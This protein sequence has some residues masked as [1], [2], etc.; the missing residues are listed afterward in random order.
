MIRILFFYVLQNF[1]S[2]I[3][4]SNFTLWCYQDLLKGIFFEVKKKFETALGV[5][6]KEKITIDPD[7]PAAVSCYAQVMKTVRE[8]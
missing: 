5:L 4:I 8:K 7:D 6:K 1:W 2:S 3:F